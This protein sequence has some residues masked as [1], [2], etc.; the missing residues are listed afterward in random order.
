[1]EKREAQ[2][3]RVLLADHRSNLMK[4]IAQSLRE[5]QRIALLPVTQADASP[6]DLVAAHRPDVLL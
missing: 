6:S 5:D 3:I 4:G 1:M 2:P